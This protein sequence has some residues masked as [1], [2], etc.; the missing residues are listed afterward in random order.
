MMHLLAIPN[1]IGAHLG[2]WRHPTAYD[3]PVMNLPRMIEYAQLAER[4]L[5][6]GLFLADGNG[7]RDMDKPALFAANFPSARPGVFD[8]VVLMTAL[9]GQTSR[10]GLVSTATTTFDEPWFVARRFASLDHVSGG[11]AGWNAVTASNAGD[12]L[13]FSHAQPVGR[14]ERYARAE[15]FVE[16]VRGLWDSWAEDAF[17]QDKASGRFLDPAK[18]RALDHAGRFF[19]VAG[20]LNVPRTPQGHPVVF[21]AGQSAAGKELAARHADAMFGAGDS[22]E[23]CQAEYADIKGRMEKYGRHPDSLRFIPGVTVFAGRSS[24]E[25]D[26]L[27]EELNALV[28]PALG[29]D[30]LSKIVTQDLSGLP[31]D[32]PMPELAD[33]VVGSSTV[34]TLVVKQIR[35]GNMTVREAA[36]MVVRDFGTPVV[37]GSATEV[38]DMLEDWYRGG[39]CDGFVLTFPVVPLGLQNFVE[40]V[41]PELQ[42]RG[43]FRREYTGTMLRDHLR[44]P[45]PERR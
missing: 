35:A 31:L 42:R 14:E 44:L 23:T 34:R 13:N 9:A 21:T 32:G 1:M 43:L 38:A 12:A 28:P 18:V 27:Y 11:R 2:G 33:A 41:V 17:V 40:L 36:R 24:A 25:A 3:D 20:P 26:E 7:I 45:Q 10:I 16:V 29:V 39:A 37:K 4:G 15:E 19:K 6:D 8:P 30:Y 5:L 22:K